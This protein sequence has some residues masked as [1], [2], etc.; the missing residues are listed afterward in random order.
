MTQPIHRLNCELCGREPLE[1]LV[2]LPPDREV[3]IP[4][5]EF[6]HLGAR[7]I[8]KHGREHVRQLLYERFEEH[9]RT[10]AD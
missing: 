3:C 9:R 6:I 10:N 4:C 1:G 7:M 2:P 5:R 8:R